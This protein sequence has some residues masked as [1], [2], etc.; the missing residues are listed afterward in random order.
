MRYLLIPVLLV[1]L[2]LTSATHAAAPDVSNVRA[3]QREGTKLVD[4]YYDL[5]NDAGELSNIHIEVSLDGG[6]T[7]RLRANAITG[8]VGS[9]VAADTNKLAVWNAGTDFD[10]NFADNCR[11]RVAAYENNY[12]TPPAGMAYIPGG[13]F[14]MGDGTNDGPITFVYV[15]PYFIDRTEV[16]KGEFNAIRN[17]AV[18][19][20]Y[21]IPAANGPSDQHPAHDVRWTRAV[22]FAN[23]KSEYYG[24]QPCYYT[25]ST[26]STVYRSGGLQNLPNSYVDWDANGYRLPTEAEWEKAARGGLTNKLY[27]WGDAA[28]S[29]A[30][31]AYNDETDGIHP[32]ASGFNSTVPVA[33]F[34]PNDS[35]LYDMTGNILEFCWDTYADSYGIDLEDPRGISAEDLGLSSV[36]RVARGGS[37]KTGNL[38]Q[39]TNGWREPVAEHNGHGLRLVTNAP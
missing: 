16:T 19:N 4:I 12:P 28:I 7:W 37:G 29:H 23:A 30:L 5:S 15:S 3:S 10:G 20:G 2:L 1:G 21:D 35:G 25:D 27:S 14:Q 22:R 36:Y 24:R 32:D 13:T 39:L 8:D 33:S 11:V 6:S 26:H 9:G 38:H 18:E 17:W 31:A 34:P